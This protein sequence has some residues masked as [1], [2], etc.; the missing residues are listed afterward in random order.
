M[1][2]PAAFV[3]VG[4]GAAGVHLVAAWGAVEILHATLAMANLAGFACA[5][6]VS[7]AGQRRFTF[8]SHAPLARSLGRWLA[9]AIAGF[10][11][12]QVLF[13]AIVA[14]WPALPYLAVLA[15][16]TL[17]VAVASFLLG[18]FWAF[19]GPVRT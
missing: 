10:L 16:V 7:F 1:P 11:L 6:A 2:A 18:R 9:T 5:F 8:R 17:A 12:N 15:G 3:L 4:A 14:R 19:A 13:L